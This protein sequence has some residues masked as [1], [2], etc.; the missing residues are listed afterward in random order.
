MGL[1]PIKMTMRK[2]IK[3]SDTDKIDLRNERA[4]NEVLQKEG[5]YS[6]SH[7]FPIASLQFE[8]TTHCN[9]FCKHCYNN[10]GTC[11]NIPD[12]MTPEK[13]IEFAKYRKR[14][15]FLRIS[16]PPSFAYNCSR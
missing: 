14:Q 6:K 15:I 4:I 10:S 1:V 16:C 13:W 2:N 8:L 5:I 3:F 9:V 7:M 12:L 11:N